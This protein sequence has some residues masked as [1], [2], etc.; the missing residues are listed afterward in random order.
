M[1]FQDHEKDKKIILLSVLAGELGFS[2]ANLNKLA[3]A[4]K[5]SAVRIHG[6][7]YSSRELLNRSL[8]AISKTEP[9]LLS[10][11][12]RAYV[13]KIT[14]NHSDLRTAL[15]NHITDDMDGPEMID[16]EE[17]I[18]SEWMEIAAKGFNQAVA[19]FK[20]AA[21]AIN[22]NKPGWRRGIR[23]RLKQAAFFVSDKSD[24]AGNKTVPG[25]SDRAYATALAAIAVLALSGSVLLARYQ[26]R[27]AEA[28]AGVNDKIFYAQAGLVE[29]MFFPA[30]EFA[31][32]PEPP[33][34]GREQLSEFIRKYGAEL[35]AG[36]SGAAGSYLI[37]A[38]DILGRVAGAEE[39]NN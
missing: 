37:T 17:G 29:K 36:T 34:P 6:R 11:K 32:Q 2:P 14:H 8:A 27:L 23:L 3:Q 28:I 33:V 12:M 39:I 22:K 16:P 38:E 7:F 26:P 31:S 4:G 30:S 20:L 24:E 10:E 1:H 19:E 35:K 18:I 25:F 21:Q 15:E 13:Y 9:G 5:L